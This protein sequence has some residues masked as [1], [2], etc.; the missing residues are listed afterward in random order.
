MDVFGD[1][2]T[3][4]AS[5]IEEDWISRVRGRDI[6][7]LPGD[8]SWAMR[9]ED[10]IPHIEYIGR[11]PGRKIIIKGNH[12][13]WWSSL[14]RLRDH[15]PQGMYAIQN[16]CLF[17]DGILFSGSRGWSLPAEQTEASDKKIFA[18]ELIRLEMSLSSAR[19]LSS[20]APLI[21]MTHFPPLTPQLLDTDVTALLEKY[22][23]NFLIYGHLHGA[24][25]KN[26]FNGTHNGVSYRCASC[27]GLDFKLAEILDVEC[28]GQ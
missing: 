7:L 18:R 17:L 9:F 10:A 1:Q 24:S 22:N 13:F 11:L 23:V 5:R 28:A 3:G 14:S 16:D 6:V 4:H 8:L 19:K 25:L 27:D 21:C 2:W 15:L 12:D 26:A 20:D